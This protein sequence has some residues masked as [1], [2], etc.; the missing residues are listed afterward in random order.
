MFWKT[1]GILLIFAI[2]FGVASVYAGKMELTTYYPAPS[3]DYDQLSANKQTYTSDKVQPGTSGRLRLPPQLGNPD[4]TNLGDIWDASIA[5]LGEI[6]YSEAKKG[7]VIFDGT[8]WASVA[9]SSGKTCVVKY[10]W[11]GQPMD[12]HVYFI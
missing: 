4:K 9:G 8:A 10:S 3:G 11:K 2:C 5:K 7:L 6:A 12:W 1:S